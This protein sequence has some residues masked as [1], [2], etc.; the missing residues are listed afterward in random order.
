MEKTHTIGF[1]LRPPRRNLKQSHGG[2]P[3]KLTFKLVK[4]KIQLLE[5]VKLSELLG[6]VSWAEVRET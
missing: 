6:Y 3:A 2:Q 5:S 4:R 1:K